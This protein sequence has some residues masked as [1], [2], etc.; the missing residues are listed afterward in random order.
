[1]HTI[2]T[3]GTKTNGKD[4]QLHQIFVGDTGGQ[5]APSSILDS[6]ARLSELSIML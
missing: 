5:E 6:G 2:H 4:V 3:E 1:M